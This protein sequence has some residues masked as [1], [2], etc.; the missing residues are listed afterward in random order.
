MTSLHVAMVFSAIANKGDIAYPLLV[1]DEKKAPPLLWKERAMQPE[2]AALLRD[3]LVK[4]VADP[5][6][7]GHGAYIPGAAI[8]GKTGTAELKASKDAEGR[9]NGWFVGFDANDPEL[10]LSVMIE[11]VKG[12]GGS[13]YVASAVKRIFQQTGIE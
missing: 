2:T 11:N 12:R 7:V 13:K 9:E 6:G 8:A 1:P 5:A 10:L 4:A 3:V